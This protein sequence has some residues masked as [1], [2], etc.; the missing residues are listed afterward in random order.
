M[1]KHRKTRSAA[2]S[3]LVSC[4]EQLENRQLLSATIDLTNT[5]GGKSVSVSS[6]GQVVNLDV[7]AVIDGADADA[8]NDAYSLLMGSFSSSN[9]GGVT[10]DLSATVD[11]KFT[12]EGASNG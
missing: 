11:S 5:G 7:W 12:L 2:S 6:V 10:G 4:V 8:S 1:M 9:G 3:K